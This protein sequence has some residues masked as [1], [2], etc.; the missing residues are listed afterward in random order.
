MPE[1]EAVN[2]MFAGI[3]GRY[4]LANHL[5]SLGIDRGWRRTLV[6]LAAEKEPQDVVDLATGSGDVAFALKKKMPAADVAGL[7][8][9]E[10]MLEEARRKLR[11]DKRFPAGAISFRQG[12][13]LALPL[14]DASVD[15]LTIAF[16]LR[17]LE[18]RER[19]LREMLR[20]LRK[21]HGCLLVLE[22]SQPYRVLKPLYYLYLKGLLPLIAGFAT[23]RRDAYEYLA[24]S[25]E[26]FPER[27]R[28]SGE[29]RQAG[30]GRVRA[31]ALSGGIV[32]IHEA[33]PE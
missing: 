3:A 21:P 32:A 5:L 24:G 28:L 16:G 6:R 13:C 29:I 20:V 1:A 9:C 17:N 33:R 10:P 12:D 27:T 2:R 19:G 25:I 15:V 8:F 30:F 4:D 31:L 11:S 7:D 14:E 26:E 22:F 23:G 18:D